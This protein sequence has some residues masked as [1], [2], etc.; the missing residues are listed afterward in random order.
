MDSSRYPIG[1]FE[2][3]AEPTVQERKLLIEQI[4]AITQHLRQIILSLRPDDLECSYRDGGWSIQQ[5]VHHLAD[6]DMNAYLR[7]KR[8]LTED[9]P[10]TS[11]YRED[12]W[13]ALSDYR[14]VPIE[15]SLT[16][17]ETLHFRFLMLL[18][19]M[20]PEMFRRTMSTQALGVITLDVALQR[21]V[22]HNHHHIAQVI[23]AVK[24][25]GDM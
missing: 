14:E 19:D 23:S 13:A 16:L 22:W 8:A 20:T 15:N 4:P 21:F 24:R 11:S 12:L 2:P 5:I 18:K 25:K 17:L 1:S 9:E 6:N 10:K 7:F 3:I